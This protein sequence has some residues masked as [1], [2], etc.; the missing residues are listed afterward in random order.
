M[1][2]LFIETKYEGEIKLS[3]DLLSRLPSKLMLAMPVQFID[4]IDS[5]KGQLEEKGKSVEL[6]ES[7]HGRHKGQVL[8]CD[9]HK[10]DGGFDAFLYI[11]DGK[12]HP[13]ALLYENE[14]QVYCYNPFSKVAEVLDSGYLEGLRKKRKGQLIKFLA[15]KKIGVLVTTKPGQKQGDVEELRSRLEKKGK[16]VYV[17]LADEINFASLEDFNF[18]EAW[19]NTAC[20]RIVED[21]KSLNVSDLEEIGY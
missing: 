14:K 6:F 3:E 7:K 2:R 18:I 9:V 12:F 4:Q 15:S 11:G 5:V 19:V 17:L 10:V 21:F 16:E 1:K 13:T 8:G 20:P